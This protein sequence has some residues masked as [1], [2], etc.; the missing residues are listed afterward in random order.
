MAF[1]KP[2]SSK[3][4]VNRAGA[5]IANGSETAEDLKCLDDWRAAHG[6][7]LNTFQSMFRKH[8]QRSENKDISLVQRLKRRKTAVDKLRRKHKD[9]MR[10]IKD[11]TSMQDYAGCRLVFN[12]NQSLME[13]RNQFHEALNSRSIDH[14]LKHDPNKFNYIES[15][16]RSGYRGI[17]DILVH[18]PRAH[19]RGDTTNQA[20]HGLVAEIQ[21]RTKVQNSWATALEMADLIDNTRTKFDLEP[22]KRFQFFH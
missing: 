8:I 13:F 10:L 6:Y 16:K 3:R 21:Y 17:H 11:A 14:Y 9:G 2:P 1:P 18:R 4:Q 22:N 5:Q 19:R 7:V 15:P 12:D 20:W